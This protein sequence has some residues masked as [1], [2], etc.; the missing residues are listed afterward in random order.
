MRGIVLDSA[1]LHPED[2]TP[3]PGGPLPRATTVLSWFQSGL[4]LMLCGVSTAQW[5]MVSTLPD[6]A[7]ARG[8]FGISL[9]LSG[10]AGRRSLAAGRTT[11]ATTLLLGVA[12]VGAGL[13]AAA[14]GVGSAGVAVPGITL[15][16]VIT[17]LLASERSVHLM[18][19]LYLAIIAALAWAEHTGRLTGPA[20]LAALGLSDRIVNLTLLGLGAWL[21]ALL[22]GRLVAGALGRERRQ[23]ERL[24]A[25]VRM[26]S[27]WSWEMDAQGRVTWLSSSFEARTGHTVAEYLRLGEPGGPQF[28]PDE[29]LDAVRAAMR[30]REPYRERL[31]GYRGVDGHVLYVRGSGEPRFDTRGTLTGWWGVSR[32]VTADLLA[33][34]ARV[35]EQRLLD[36]LVQLSPD[37]IAVVDLDSGRILLAN[38]SFVAMS[39]RNEHDV[40]GRHAVELGLWAD[41]A[42]AL[43]LRDALHDAPAVH[44]L[45]L[46]VHAADGSLR[47]LQVAAARFEW[48]GTPA[49]VLVGRDITAMEQARRETEAI[50]DKAAVGIAFVRGRRFDR[51]NPQFEHIFGVPTGSLAGTPTRGMFPDDVAFDQ[52]AQRADQAHHAG[53]LIDI[54]RIV[55]RPDGSRVTVR[56]R[57]QALDPTQ[58]L[59]GGAIWIAEDVGERR[60]A[61][62]ELADAKHQAEAANEAK[63]SFLA[64]MSH[65]IRTPLNGVLGLARLLQDPALAATRRQDYL[66]HLVHA[67]EG[68]AGIVSDV[69]D[70]SKIEAGELE[71]ER[72]AFD[73]HELLGKVFRSFALLGQERGLDMHLRID[74]AV[75]HRVLGDPLRL[76]QILANYLSNALKFTAEGDITLGAEPSGTGLRLTVADTGPGIAPTLQERLFRPFTQADSSTTRRFGGTG[77]GL[78]ICRE[79]AECMGGAVGVDSMPGEGSRFWVDLPLPPA[80]ETPSAEAPTT[81]DAQALL[82]LRVLVAEDNAVNM[83][84]VATLLRT[85]GAE[86]LEAHDGEDAVQCA[87]REDG[88]L[89]VVLMDLHM[90]HVDGLEATRRLRQDPRTAQLPVYALSAAVLERDREQAR[91]AG[92]Q[93]FIA[94]P[95]NEADL[96]AA[97]APLRRRA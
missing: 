67:A 92:M 22:A 7:V 83:L 12:A 29:D 1:D 91:A 49:A 85:L 6:A 13:A 58:P 40:I 66:A 18:T 19:G 81:E 74:P 46:P 79:L 42:P 11:W 43:R 21:A 84:I 78:S 77:L 69:L 48:D 56:L 90:P 57:A 97:L 54:E 20:E 10:W 14:V 50:L 60:R 30:A 87:L 89:D 65:E 3:D 75:P 4:G 32:N 23:A 37:A 47:E 39:G 17:G 35:R 55:P 16:I 5:L 82:G 61:E 95:V 24:S 45:R 86:V 96:V 15:L 93:G 80:A 9:L 38:P 33:Q 76:R 59:P 68:L 34:R 27:D 26:G 28:L 2:A 52:F 36:R 73:L 70:L 53:R 31:V 63:S 94:K 25:L 62:Q 71:I 64:T 8:V 41:W 72:I 51:V 88:A 44:D